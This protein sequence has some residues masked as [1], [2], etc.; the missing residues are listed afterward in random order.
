MS[1]PVQ[2]PTIGNHTSEKASR[3]SGEGGAG[4]DDVLGESRRSRIVIH[5]AWVWKIVGSG[6]HGS[7]LQQ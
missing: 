5:K 7:D 2:I 4:A 3:Y 6:G 1:V